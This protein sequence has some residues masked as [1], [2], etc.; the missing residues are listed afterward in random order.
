ME[1]VARNLWQATRS[2][3][4][5]AWCGVGCQAKAASAAARAET[6][7]WWRSTSVHLVRQWARGGHTNLAA[8]A[9]QVQR[10]T[11]QVVQGGDFKRS[12]RR[13]RMVAT[14]GVAYEGGARRRLQ[15]RSG[16]G[17]SSWRVS[18]YGHNGAVVA[19]STVAHRRVRA[20]A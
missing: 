8:T 7:S 3:D 16:S 9:A 19:A 2:T 12:V 4:D 5:E 15:V 17:V 13:R 10:A 14:S 6:T 18:G 20:G 1:G 11:R